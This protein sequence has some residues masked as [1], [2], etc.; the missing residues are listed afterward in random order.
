MP[1]YCVGFASFEGVCGNRA[2]HPAEEDGP[3][4]WCD[5]CHG[6][7]EDYREAKRKEDEPY[8]TQQT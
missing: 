8:G 6:M 2:V 1:V 5:R 4:Y 7:I 3:K